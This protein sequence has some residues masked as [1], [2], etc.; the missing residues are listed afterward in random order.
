MRDEQA[1]DP[2][3]LLYVEEKRQDLLPRSCI[4][5]G[6]RLI[7]DQKFRLRD[8]R[9]CDTDPLP[10]SPGEFP[11][12]TVCI[13]P[14]QAHQLQHSADPFPRLKRLI[15]PAPF[16]PGSPERFLQRLSSSKAWIQGS[17]WI[18]EHHLDPASADR[19]GLFPVKPPAP[20]Q[21]FSAV[22][23]QDPAQDPGKGRL[24]AAALSRQCKDLSFKDLQRNVPD[25]LHS[26]E[27]F[28]Q[29]PY[30][31]QRGLLLP[32]D[33]RSPEPFRIAQE[34]P[35]ICFPGRIEDVLRGPGLYDPSPAHHVHPA[36]QSGGHSHIMAH[37]KERS[38][39]LPY[40][41]LQKKDD[42]R[43]DRSVKSSRRLIR[44]D[45]FRL[46][47]K[48]HGDDH[49]LPHSAGQFEGILL[50]PEACIVDPHQIQ[51]L[52][53]PLPRLLPSAAPPGTDGLR[54]LPPDLHRRIQTALGILEH[55]RRIFSRH[56]RFPA[57]RNPVKAY[58]RL[59]SQ[60]THNRQHSCTLAGSGL[61][62]KP[63][64]LPCFHRKRDI[65]QRSVPGHP[66]SGRAFLHRMIFYIQSLYVKYFHSVFSLLSPI[67][68]SAAV[69]IIFS[70]RIITH[71]TTR[72][73]TI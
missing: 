22:L 4:Q 5:R 72:G 71:S 30:L 2:G 3:L 55:H 28:G 54:D 18:L 27:F 7:T 65:V 62:H 16:P 1:G 6:Q 44:D 11:R 59:S 31:Q 32:S 15:C 43:L 8:Q 48:R 47:G 53:R 10:L 45:Q 73:Y 24:P 19:T 63:H 23:L 69:P 68:S 35:G 20:V 34:L 13:L 40:D 57:Q 50:H 49:S 56:R 58:V 42:L 14:A 66:A 37:Q 29:M 64:D 25:P 21:H 70:A 67:L 38:P 33:R 17:I 26:L 9:P 41:P 52:F 12:I 39:C 51:K 36:A 46:T 61:S 60:K